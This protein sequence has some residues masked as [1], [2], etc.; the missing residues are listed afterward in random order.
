MIF[1]P[2][3]QGSHQ[4][5]GAVKGSGLVLSLARDSVRKMH[6]ELV[7]LDTSDGNVCFRIELP[8]PVLEKNI[9]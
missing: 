4:R 8:A 6:G 7:L 1:E 3:Y 5:K 2:F 9:T